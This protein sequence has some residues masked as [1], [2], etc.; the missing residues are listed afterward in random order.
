MVAAV[1][2]VQGPVLGNYYELSNVCNGLPWWLSGKES[3]FNA[4]DTSTIPGSG[5]SPGEGK[6]NHSSILAWR[7]PWTEE[8]RRVCGV[9]ESDTT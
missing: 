9:T 2:Q 6:A 3:A 8:P 4:G 5:R 1:Y 7:I